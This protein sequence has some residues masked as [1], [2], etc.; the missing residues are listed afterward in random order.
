MSTPHRII[1]FCLLLTITVFAFHET[2]NCTD[3]TAPPSQ[4]SAKTD[5]TTQID[6][7]DT[8][9]KNAAKIIGGQ[10][11]K[12]TSWPW[13]AALLNSSTSDFY[14]A[15]FCGGVLIDDSWILTAAHC[16]TYDKIDRP[17]LPNDIE[18]SVGIHDLDSFNGPRHDVTAIYRH[19]DYDT[20]SLVNDI[21][22]LR[23]ATPSGQQPIQLFS[24]ETEEELDGSLI[25]VM[26]T[27]IGWGRNSSI[28]SGYYPTILQQVELPVVSNNNCSAYYGPLPDSQICAG[29]SPGSGKDACVGDSGGPLMVQVDGQWAHTG[30]VSYGSNCSSNGDYGVYTRTSSFIDFILQYVPNAQFTTNPPQP[31][32]EPEPEPEPHT[33]PLTGVYLLLQ[34]P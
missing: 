29:Y 5:F 25:G 22:L 23:L 12:S 8:V 19:P 26:T 33:C 15:Q 20:T 14:N 24:G 28:N 10:D 17:K 11:A 34:T 9:E 3:L 1:H 27:L 32:P 16:V 6:T 31:E 13:M 7:P 18:V 4:P 21:A 30:L 2:G